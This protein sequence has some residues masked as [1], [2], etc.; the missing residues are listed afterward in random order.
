MRRIASPL[1]LALLV[2]IVVPWHAGCGVTPE[3]GPP[4]EPF[5]QQIKSSEVSFDMVWV[6]TGGFWIGKHEVTWNEYLLY[7]DFEKEGKVPPG[8]DGVS[9]PSKPLDDVS[10]YDRDWGLGRRPAVGMS[11]NAA[12]KYCTW[13]SINTGKLFRLPTETEW[14]LACGPLPTDRL[15]DYAW[16]EPNGDEM[17]HEVGKKLPNAIGAHDMFGNL[18][19]YCNNPFSAK[20]PERAVL[21]GGSWDEPATNVTP[22]SRLGFEDDWV[23]A[24]PN[25]PSGVWWVPDGNHLGFR[26]V[27][28]RN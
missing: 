6:P 7:C 16:F 24:D 3:P 11:L 18:W 21:R 26:V 4:P 1:R 5:R 14:E 23:L 2:L 20:E 8:V 19:E 9:K 22:K 15:T 17:T 28:D 13:L 25:V 10:P 27:C 12:R